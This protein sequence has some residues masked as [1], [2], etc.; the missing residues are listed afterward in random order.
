M[1]TQKDI[2]DKLGISQ[3][4][5]ACAFHPELSRNISAVKRTRIL[6]A[7]Q[8]LGYVPH[9]AARRLA[10]SRSE[11][12]AQ[13]FDQIGLIYLAKFDLDATCL[14][15]MSGAEHE[16]SRHD[17]AITFIRV[18]E[19]DEWRKVDRLTRAGGID[20]WLLYGAVNDE[21]IGRLAPAKLPYVALGDNQCSK[22]VPTANVDNR[23]VG[24]MGA[25]RLAALGHRR[26]AFWGSNMRFVY[27]R[28]TLEGFLAAARTLGLDTD[29]Q[30]IVNYIPLIDPKAPD[31]ENIDRVMRRHR[32]CGTS[33][34]KSLPTAIFVPEF[35]ITMFLHR[36]F[37]G[38]GLRIPEDISILGTERGGMPSVQNAGFTRIELS[39]NEVGRQG[40]ELL[41]RLAMGDQSLDASQQQHLIA[42]QL[43][44]GW[45]T[46]RVSSSA[47]IP[48]E[49]P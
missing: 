41:H 17:A 25:K 31:A 29:S 9:N 10:R 6:D 33:E 23:A 21:V 42:P 3:S 35:E 8:K 7:A 16:L 5:V 15:M 37:K 24:R 19:P 11:K 1:V 12:R 20:S 44:E 49:K 43:F 40:A 22:P 14:A 28:E 30:L 26:V 38:A 27:Q 36:F 18:S 39:M 47:H 46:G 48:E 32:E 34:G 2:A 13:T 45:S 4:A